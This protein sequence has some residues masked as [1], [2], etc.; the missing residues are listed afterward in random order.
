M[1]GWRQVLLWIALVALWSQYATAFDASFDL[2]AE[3][4]VDA[5]VAG[6]EITADIGGHAQLQ[7]EIAGAVSPNSFVGQGPIFG[8][9]ARNLVTLVTEGWVLL[10]ASGQLESGDSITIQSLV[11]TRRQGLI[12]LPVGELIE[13]SHYTQISTSDSYRVVSGIASGIITGG[14]VPSGKA[15][16]LRLEG[17]GNFSFGGDWHSEQPALC[18]WDVISVDHPEFPPD[19]YAA[20][21]RVFDPSRR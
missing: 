3:G 2:T 16:T 19:L 18:V 5:L 20:I 12:T 15:M 10:D 9:G 13:V 4:W 14:I 21:V 1:S 17:E 6:L 8:F 7:G 11:Y